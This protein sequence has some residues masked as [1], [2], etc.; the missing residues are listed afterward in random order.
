MTPLRLTLR[1][2]LPGGRSLRWALAVRGGRAR[3][4]ASLD[5]R[6]L[7][8]GTLRAEIDDGLLHL[9]GPG[10]LLRV[11]LADLHAPRV[12]YARTDLLADL[13]LRGGTYR[14][15][16]CA[17]TPAPEPGRATNTRARVSSS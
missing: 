8:R 1:W 3:A 16:A 13:Q 7:R 2:S 17:V 9:E 10:G 12:L 5:G 4:V 15:E 14:L 11:T 6:P